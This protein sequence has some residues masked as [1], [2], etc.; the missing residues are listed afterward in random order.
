MF[1]IANKFTALTT[2]KPKEYLF[3]VAAE[4][5]AALTGIPAGE[6]LDAKNDPTF[7]LTS[8][9]GPKSFRENLIAIKEDEEMFAE[10]I[11]LWKKNFPEKQ[12]LLG[13]ICDT[14]GAAIDSIVGYVGRKRKG[15]EGSDGV[16]KRQKC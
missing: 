1:S 11:A 6:I 12:S 14:A 2:S 9:Q 5:F 3:K 8:K 16:G 4:Q 13:T 10:S 7:K 15:V